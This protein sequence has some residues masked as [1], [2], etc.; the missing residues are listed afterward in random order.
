[1]GT[2]GHKLIQFPERKPGP[3]LMQEEES[4]FS[5]LVLWLITELSESLQHSS[6]FQ[7][8]YS[9]VVPHMSSVTPVLLLL[10]TKK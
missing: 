1:M 9:V 6:A 3:G 10:T 4:Q 2:P 5:N 8:M 7:L